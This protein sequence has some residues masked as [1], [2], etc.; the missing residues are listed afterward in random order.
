MGVGMKTL[1]E[2]KAAYDD[3]RDSAWAAYYAAWAA[4]CETA[5]AAS[6]TASD[7]ASDAF[8]AYLAKL[9]EVRNENIG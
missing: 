1:D 8:D 2:L 6:R 9:K 7:A 4:E 5:W 3:A